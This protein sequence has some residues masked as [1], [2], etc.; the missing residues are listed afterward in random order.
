MYALILLGC[1]KV[2]LVIFVYCHGYLISGTSFRC[3]VFIFDFLFE[4]CFLKRMCQM[5]CGDTANL[6]LIIVPD[7]CQT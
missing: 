3:R 5:Y 6:V 7:I 1:L 2:Q 4:C